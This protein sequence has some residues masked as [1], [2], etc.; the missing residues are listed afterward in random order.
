M[1]EWLAVWI[2]WGQSV[3][4]GSLGPQGC[5]VRYT[6]GLKCYRCRGRGWSTGV[7]R[8]IG[9]LRN[10]V[11][12]GKKR[13]NGRIK[14]RWWKRK[15]RCC[16]DAACCSLNNEATVKRD[17]LLLCRGGLGVR[18]PVLVRFLYSSFSIL[19]VVCVCMLFFETRENVF[20]QKRKIFSTNPKIHTRLKTRDISV[21]NNSQ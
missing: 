15:S 19:C 12:R 10:G 9:R 2:G 13:G 4:V 20:H 21:S 14:A 8:G 6:D 18:S 5:V 7:I 11:W 1:S 3:K 16:F 17:N